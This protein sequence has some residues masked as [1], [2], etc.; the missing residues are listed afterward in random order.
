MTVKHVEK[1]KHILQGIM[2]RSMCIRRNSHF[3]VQK[4]RYIFVGENSMYFLLLYFIL[5]CFIFYCYI[6]LL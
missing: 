2:I 3:P 5:L 4:S 6:L 1:R